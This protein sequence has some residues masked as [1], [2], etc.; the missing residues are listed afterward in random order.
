MDIYTTTGAEP[1][2]GLRP[3]FRRTTGHLDAPQF[4]PSGAS[5]DGMSVPMIARHE[6]V[7]DWDIF[8]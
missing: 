2:I 4:L 1:V 5:D 3:E 7:W 8:A 6:D